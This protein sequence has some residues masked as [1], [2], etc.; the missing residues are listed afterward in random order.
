MNRTQIANKL[1]I[2]PSYVTRLLNK[3]RNIS[4]S[5]AEKLHALFPKRTV[6]QWKKSSP[7]QIKKAFKLPKS[8][9]TQYKTYRQIEFAKDLG[10][11]SES[12]A[13]RLLRGKYAI[14]WKLAARLAI[15]FPQKDVFGWEAAT[16][17]DI[18]TLFNDLK[19]KAKKAV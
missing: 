3:K 8:R 1:K 16:K 18:Q 14:S 10:F 11:K 12:V 2:D 19:D 7:S 15:K 4:D 13:N 6:K 9:P 5:I 17:E